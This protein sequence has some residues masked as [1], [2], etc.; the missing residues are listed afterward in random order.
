M[1]C[2]DS[3]VWLPL[4]ILVSRVVVIG[5][6]IGAF[7]L[8]IVVVMLTPVTVGLESLQFFVLFVRPLLPHVLQGLDVLRA[9]PPGVGEVLGSKRPF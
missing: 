2:S 3:V 7:A 9:S 6:M 1:K 5:L 4:A 8:P